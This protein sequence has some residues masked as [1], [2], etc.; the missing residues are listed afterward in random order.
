MKLSIN[1]SNI[2]NSFYEIANLLINEHTLQAEN[3]TYQ[4]SNIEFYY[5]NEKL[6]RDDNSHALKYKRA[7]VRQLLNSQWY[8][9]KRSINP[10]FKHKGIDFTF[11][12]GINFGGILI[13]EVIRTKDNKRFSQSKF[14]DE[15]INVMG[16]KDPDEFIKMIEEQEKLTFKKSGGQ[17]HGIAKRSRIGLVNETFKDSLYAFKI[18]D[19]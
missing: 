1:Q 8:V 9:H 13:K 11:G 14:V 5:Y 19:S 12:D 10:N 15:L 17:N 18:Q 7:K 2:E 3:L 16:P 6:H 4:I